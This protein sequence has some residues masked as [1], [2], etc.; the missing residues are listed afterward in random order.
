MQRV[1]ND[2]YN[3]DYNG[4]YVCHFHGGKR[5]Q[6]QELVETCDTGAIDQLIIRL[7]DSR[8]VTF[9]VISVSADCRD[10]RARVGGDDGRHVQTIGGRDRYGNPRMATYKVIHGSEQCNGFG[11][12]IIYLSSP[13]RAPRHDGLKRG[14]Y[15]D[16]DAVHGSLELAA[17]VSVTVLTERD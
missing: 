5:R 10:E 8:V 6:Y 7:R 14:M 3:D 11:Q 13:S 12:R 1:Y 2:D 4:N 15:L 9:N 17:I 16:R